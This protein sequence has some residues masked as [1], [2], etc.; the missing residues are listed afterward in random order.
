[1]VVR[2]TRMNNDKVLAAAIEAQRA[3]AKARLLQQMATLGLAAEDG[4]QVI[5]MVKSHPQGSAI[6]FRPLHRRL[7]SPEIETR[8]V[9]ASDGTP[10]L[11]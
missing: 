10:V 7:D 6:V 8:V 9:I 4:W 11:E 2:S 1:M 3:T 5:E